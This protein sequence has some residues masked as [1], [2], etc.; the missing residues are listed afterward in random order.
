MTAFT[1]RV[2][3]HDAEDLYDD[4]HKAMSKE[5]FYRTIL[6]DEVRYQLPTAEYSL[7]N[8]DLLAQE[9]LDKAERAANSV[10]SKPQPS[11]LVTRT[12]IRRYHSGLKIVK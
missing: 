3:L 9:V 10:K 7:P 4:L 1:V 8:S 12:E 2:E 11:I 6:I 5:G